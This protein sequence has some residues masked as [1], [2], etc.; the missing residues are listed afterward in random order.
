MI[1][2]ALDRVLA[3]TAVEL[4]AFALCEI[5]SDAQ[6]SIAPLT[7]IEVH[8]VL[9]GDLHLHVEGAPPLLLGPGSVVIVPTGRAQRL[10]ASAAPT[11]DHPAPGICAMRAD[12]LRLYDAR[13]GG[14]AGLRIMCA[15]I[16]ADVTGHLGLFDTLAV[17]IA[18]RLE[19]C[20][21]ITASLDAMLAEADAP[22]A[23]SRSLTGALMKA[24]LILAL[25]AHIA[26][27]G[28]ADLPG[29]FGRAWLA[30]AVGAVLEAPAAA[31]SVGG[32]AAVAGRSRSTFAKG[33]C[34]QMGVTPME[35][36]SQ[37]RLAHA[38]RLL[39]QGEAPITDIAA[40]AGFA[41]RSH[42]SRLF[43]EA[44]GTDPRRFRRSHRAGRADH[45]DA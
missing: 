17:P 18:A 38:H 22:G 40:R 30:R 8:F 4:S 26:R 15:Q 29:L 43:R 32:L 16:Q 6:I 25:R 14:P 13:S 41:S 1:V 21:V 28:I 7:A 3:A 10:A 27:H 23:F 2:P 34:E 11:R 24:S 12:G 44:Y 19:A 5:A 35:F 42:F 36:V 45:A 37:A 39:L 31:H 9:C 33:F 20:P